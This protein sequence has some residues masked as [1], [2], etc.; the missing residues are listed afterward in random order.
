MK[1]IMMLVVLVLFTIALSACG[2]GEGDADDI[3]DDDPIVD[4][5]NNDDNDD[6]DNGDNDD[7]DNGD[8]GD[9][10]NDD[11]GDN[12]NGDDDDNDNGD[13]GDD[14]DEPN[15]SEEEA[16]ALAL[17][18]L[19]EGDLTF[20]ADRMET[21]DLAT[22]HEIETVLSVEYDD[23][24]SEETETVVID[25]TE[26][27]IEYAEGVLIQQEQVFTENGETI[28]TLSMITDYEGDSMTIYVDITDV[29][30]QL[31]DMVDTEFLDAFDI[32]SGWVKFTF[33]DSM[34][35]MLEV[36]LFGDFLHAVVVAQ[37][38]TLEDLESIEDDFVAMLGVDKASANIEL[39]LLFDTLFTFDLNAIM[40][41][42]FDINVD[43][44]I[45]GGI[46]NVIEPDLL[47][48][49]ETYETELKDAGIPYDTYYDTLSNDGL[50]ELLET[51]TAS[52]AVI[53][54][55]YLG[56]PYLDVLVEEYDSSMTLAENAQAVIVAIL[57]SMQEDIETMDG[58][59][60][61]ALYAVIDTLDVE[62]FL[63][64]AETFDYNAMVMSL[65]DGT[66]MNFYNNM[67]ETEIKMILSVFNEMLI[68]EFGPITAVLSYDV[69]LNDLDRFTTY[70][71]ISTYLT[72]P[73]MVSS[74]PTIDD[75][76]I[77][78]TEGYITYEMLENISLSFLQDAYAWL[79]QLAYIEL[80][81]VDPINCDGASCE[82]TFDPYIQLMDMLSTMD[83]MPVTF[84][85][86]PMDDETMWLNA[87]IS[88][89]INTLSDPTGDTEPY[90]ATLDITIRDTTTIEDIDEFTDLNETLEEFAKFI[91]IDEIRLL[92]E[93]IS[94]NAELEEGE[95]VTLESVIDDVPQTLG[96]FDASL[97][98]F[99]LDDGDLEADFVYVDGVDVFDD[100]VTLSQLDSIYSDNTVTRSEVLDQIGLL[101]DTTF[102]MTRLLL[103]FMSDMYYETPEYPEYPEDP[104]Y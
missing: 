93:D 80:P 97:T 101:D 14:D 40:A 72:D 27:Y 44:L 81:E 88:N 92:M 86:D 26:R 17:T 53:V 104:M 100:E 73:D 54:G 59:D 33:S 11:N 30:D 103:L 83:D 16:A 9:N 18:E 52:D 13:N 45:D 70:T 62:L 24:F 95:T 36:E 20:L 63:T 64:Q 76:Y 78:E 3:V 10:D 12:D 65:V 31:V 21:M 82:E 35:N 50:F 87:D 32:E 2:L 7:N 91:F 77:V 69:L 22:M 74:E 89:L 6:N 60:Y 37:D 96:I 71:D 57:P 39:Q 43:L 98:T 28:A 55:G 15:I 48:M 42:I 85:V 56:I 41:H 4:D 34:T 67:T 19:Y 84:T 75:D 5:D 25:L 79:D 51:M 58:I 94:M 99:T 90:T 46:E 61:D 66:Y 47:S 23:E 102:S 68:D 1:K 8:N 29:Y 49:M 38:P